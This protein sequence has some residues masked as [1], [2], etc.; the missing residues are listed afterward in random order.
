MQIDVSRFRAAFYVEAAEHLEHME[1]ALLQL[2]DAPRD[3][4]LLNTI[5]RA[6]HSIKGASTTF[7]IEEVGKFT[8]VLETLLERMR[9]GVLQANSELI[10]LLLTSVDVITGLLANAKDG[11]PLPENLAIVFGELQRINGA[12]TATTAESMATPLPRQEEN[13]PLRRYRVTLNPSREFY[14][15]GQEPLLLLRELQDLGRVVE[16]KVD[17]SKLPCLDEL[18]PEDC[19]LSWT[20][21]IESG[22]E[23]QAF[24][25]VF[26]FLDAGSKYSV[27]VCEA[28]LTPA[29]QE[30]TTASGPSGVDAA[31]VEQPANALPASPTG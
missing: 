8:H 3:M 29:D 28:A 7:G 5:F 20:L 17:A 27:D 21:D 15:F 13:V 19:Y 25:D 9:D 31:H 14:R 24:H 6:A 23:G 1:A 26:M 11:A 12:E 16:L 2:E 10:E 30:A 18:H 22:Q 4:E